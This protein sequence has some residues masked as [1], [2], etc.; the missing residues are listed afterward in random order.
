MASRTQYYLWAAGRLCVALIFIAAGILKVA[1]GEVGAY[2]A[3]ATHLP[4]TLLRA[5][6]DPV[7][8]IKALSSPS[9]FT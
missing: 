6:A 2:F 4:G 9:S 8:W 7:S 1:E 5:I 3:Y